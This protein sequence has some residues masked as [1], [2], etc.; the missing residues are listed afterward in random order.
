[1]NSAIT[2]TKPMRITAVN[3]EKGTIIMW[4]KNPNNSNDESDM[5]A[6]SYK[7]DDIYY[8][9]KHWISLTYLI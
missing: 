8:L 7:K 9:I 2:R 3:I 4:K 5:I 1:M 6:F